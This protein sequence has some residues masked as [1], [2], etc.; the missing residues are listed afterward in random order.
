MRQVLT[1]V[2]IVGV[3]VVFVV[4]AFNGAAL[5]V[6]MPKEGSFEFDL[7]GVVQLEGG[8]QSDQ[9]SVVHYTLIANT[10]TEPAGRP[11]DQRSTRCWPTA[12]TLA[13][14]SHEVG[15]CEAVDPDEDKW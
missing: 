8:I 10:R 6:D 13:G 3:V 14:K 9:L 11:F 7:C 15:Y 5:A 4:A 1:K 12:G 2:G